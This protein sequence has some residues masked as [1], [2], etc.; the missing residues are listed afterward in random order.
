MSTTSAVNDVECWTQLAHKWL[1][2][3]SLP[4]YAPPR[5]VLAHYAAALPGATQSASRPRL[6]VLGATPALADL[7]L[8]HG[9]E[10][11]RVDQCAKMFDAARLHEQPRDRAL[12]HKILA[13]WSDLSTLASGSIDAVV[14]DCALNNVLHASMADVLRELARVLKPGGG[15]SLRQVVRSE[16]PP[17]LAELTA[18]RRADQ[19]S[20]SAFRNAVRHCVQVKGAFDAGTHLR[21]AGVVFAMVDAAQAA[22]QLQEAEYATL[23]DTRSAL[24]LTTYL[25]AEQRDLLQ[26]WLGPCE[27]HVTEQVP[28]ALAPTRMFVGRRGH[29]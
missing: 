19:L 5:D 15:Y 8:A 23:R 11:M 1:A 13:D 12:E 6:L 20:M 10:V 26:R 27:V 18:L 4:H 25:E 16:S 9:L 3:G 17:T 21:D 2:R 24:R 29:A 22:G 28:I 7:G 14:G